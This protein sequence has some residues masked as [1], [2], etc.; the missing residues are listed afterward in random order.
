ML[1]RHTCAVLSILAVSVKIVATMRGQG[2]GMRGEGFWIEIRHFF[3]P[4]LI[5]HVVAK[6]Q[7]IL[8]FRD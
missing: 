6:I 8:H 5:P 1:D 3:D 2:R 4:A 7:R